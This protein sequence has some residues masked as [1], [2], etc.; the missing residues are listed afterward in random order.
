[1]RKGIFTTVII[2]LFA[3]LLVAQERRTTK[4]V[5]TAAQFLKIGVHAGGMGMG[6]SAVAFPS[7]LSA[8]HWNPAGLSR[9]NTQEVVFTQSKWIADTDILYMA[10]SMNFG[11]YGTVGAY[12]TTLDY[13]DD[14]LVRTEEKPLGTGERFSARDLDMGLSYASN[15]TDRF[16]IGGTVKFVSQQIWHMTAQTMA[17]DL[18]ALFITPLKD[19]RL[20]MSITN[21]GGKMQPSG[22]DVRFYA[23][24][25]PILYGNNDQIPANYELSSWAIPQ[26]FRVGLSGDVGSL[27]TMKLTWAVDALHPSDNSEYINVGAELSVMERLFLRAGWRTLFAVDREGGMSMGAGIKHA[28]S[29]NFKIKLDYAYVDYGVLNQINMLT[30]SILY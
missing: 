16:S 13:G 2:L 29:P 9:F 4:T 23:D 20:G 15:L 17:L 22:R 30:F 26:T 8:L 7:S 10:A 6:E 14:M 5:T 11:R 27:K 28:F 3:G 21:F 1:M 18:G 24:P 12:M 25:D 19:I